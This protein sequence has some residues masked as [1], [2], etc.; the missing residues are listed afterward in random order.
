M[1]SPTPKTQLDIYV[2]I[3]F[4]F[5]FGINGPSETSPM[6]VFVP[7]IN[8]FAKSILGSSRMDSQIAKALYNHFYWCTMM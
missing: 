6:H 2:A 1:K 3:Y 7:A 8:Y 5:I 4:I